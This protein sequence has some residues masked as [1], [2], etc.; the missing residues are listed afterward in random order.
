MGSKKTACGECHF[1]VGSE[2]HILVFKSEH[3]AS[4]AA[5][6]FLELKESYYLPF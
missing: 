2:G 4:L 1:Y 3:Q 6:P 5:E